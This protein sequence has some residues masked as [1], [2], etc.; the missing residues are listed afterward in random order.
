LDL[1][2]DMRQLCVEIACMSL[3]RERQYRGGDHFHVLTRLYRMS[4]LC[5]IQYC[6]E[7]YLR[8]LAVC[9]YHQMLGEYQDEDHTDGSNIWEIGGT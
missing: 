8:M 5:P 3:H 9:H 6:G 7:E 4:I 2:S 1:Q